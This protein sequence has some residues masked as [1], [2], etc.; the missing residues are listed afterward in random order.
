MAPQNEMLTN[1]APFDTHAWRE[2]RNGK[3]VEWI[4]DQNAIAFIVQF[5]DFCEV[6]DDLW[7]GDKEV[8]KDDLTRILFVAL[9]EMPLNPFF[10]GFKG[11]LIPVMVTGINAWL[12]ANTMESG[13]EN[14]KVF[15]Y[16]L[17]DWYAELIAFVI[18][19]ARGRDYMRSV[20]MEVRHFFTHQETLEQYKADL[21]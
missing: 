21:S 15:A 19:L 11:Q 16:V 9:T 3:L 17:R 8:T 12:D 4:G 18:Y 2:Q 6:I 5:G 10:D 1:S 13:S 14:D 7:D 20:S